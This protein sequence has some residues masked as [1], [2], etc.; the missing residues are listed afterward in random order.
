M[1][2]L[3]GYTCIRNAIELDYPVHLTIDSLLAGCDEVVVGVAESPDG[4]LDWLRY[5]YKDRPQVRLVP[6]P[7]PS[8]D[9]DVRW[10]TRWINETRAHVDP[11]AQTL[12]LDADEVIEPKA[13][14]A[15]RAVPHGTVYTLHRLNLWRD[16]RHLC[17]DGFTCS[18]KVTRFAPASL[19]MTSDEIYRSQDFP[20]DEPPIRKKAVERLDLRIWH[21][22]FVRHREALF[23]KVEVNLRAF[24]GAGQDSRLVEAKR[25]LDLPWQDFCPYPVP[26]L[27]NPR[28]V[29][30][31]CRE[32]LR[33]RG[34][35]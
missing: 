29:P 6:Q 28:P 30:E 31:V 27:D 13:F 23:K 7:W 34:A 18:H 17:P 4:T 20:E 15:L 10:W 24:F 16:A 8:P 9:R 25:H 19:W 11:A 21:L 35:L 32:W 26:L 2:K 3:V 33:E 5:Y 22:G 12:F 1:S 14:P